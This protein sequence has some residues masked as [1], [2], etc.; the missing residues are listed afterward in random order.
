MGPGLPTLLYGVLLLALGIMIM[1]RAIRDRSPRWW[2]ASALVWA[3]TF[4]AIAVLADRFNEPRP[5][6]LPLPPP[7]ASADGTLA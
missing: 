1:R 6:D 5:R 7:P 3:A 2:I 4:A